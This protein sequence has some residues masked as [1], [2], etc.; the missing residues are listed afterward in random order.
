MGVLCVSYEELS[1]DTEMSMKY[2][3]VKVVS[4]HRNENKVLIVKIHKIMGE[5]QHG[6]YIRN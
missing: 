6:K 3:H 1:V 2:I 5:K 4:I